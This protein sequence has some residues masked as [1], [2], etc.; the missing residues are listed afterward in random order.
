MAVSHFPPS[1]VEALTAPIARVPCPE[2]LSETCIA[3]GASPTARRSV[4][5]AGD[6]C[7][8]GCV[9]T[10]IVTPTVSL[11]GVKLEPLVTSDP[12]YVP[13]AIPAA[14]AM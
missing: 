8:I 10:Y 3:M 6:A 11:S 4:T 1:V 7:A 5:C 2:L 14:G 9:V 13:C 12:L